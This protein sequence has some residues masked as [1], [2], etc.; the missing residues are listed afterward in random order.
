MVEVEHPL[1]R[2]SDQNS[3][4]E[5]ALSI[6]LSPHWVAVGIAL[7]KAICLPTVS[8]ATISFCI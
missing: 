4:Q 8:D 2:C 3:V 1:S 6:N 5:S 7:H